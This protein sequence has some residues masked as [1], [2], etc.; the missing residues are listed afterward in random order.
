M[1][2]KDK[3]EDKKEAKPKEAKPEGKKQGGGKDEKKFKRPQ[4]T[5]KVEMD[6]GETQGPIPTPRLVEK[7]KTRDHPGDAAEVRLQERHGDPPVGEA[8]DLDGRGQI[9]H[10]RR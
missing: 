1:A 7:Y 10:A 6:T 5:A 2:K 3:D 9:R 4:A 8:G